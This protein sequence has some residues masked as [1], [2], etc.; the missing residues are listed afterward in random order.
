MAEGFARKLLGDAYAVHSAGTK[1]HGMNPRAVKVMAE[2]GID[3]SAHS[4]KTTDQLPDVPMDVVFT[5]CSDAHET[6]PVFPG[7]KIIHRGFD[8]P[9]RLTESFEDE[10]KRL[11]VYRRVRDEIRDWISGLDQELKG[12]S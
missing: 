3:I 4:S 1:T 9:P 12:I 6:C 10:E 5:V 7:G 2:A 11:D 8:D